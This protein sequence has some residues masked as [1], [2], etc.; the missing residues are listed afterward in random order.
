MSG[1]V[2]RLL[3]DPPAPGQWNMAVDEW[4]LNWA[5]E[6]GQPVFRL[7]QWAPA[8]LSLGYFQRW[9]DRRQHQAS[10][11]CPMVRRP[12][13]GGAILHD[14]E[15]TYS[16]ALPYHLL[17]KGGPSALYGLI[18]ESLLEVFHNWGLAARLWQCSCPSAEVP[19]EEPFLCFERRNRWD[20]VADGPD[21]GEVKL[22]G[23]AQ[24]RIRTALLQHGSI[25]LERSPAAPEL[26]GVSELLGRSVHPEELL[27][28]WLGRLS[29]KLPWRRRPDSLTPHEGEA[30][31]LLVQSKYGSDDW[32]LRR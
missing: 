10:F 7:Y 16:L 6:S 8:T 2:C 17:P 15:L 5:V 26:P 3:I 25:L 29:E 9:Q 21:G 24:R 22:V 18:H 1:V 11:H 28:E 12:S 31:E 20:I 23:S 27:Q 30:V 19:P 4:L 32:N 13:G 14:R